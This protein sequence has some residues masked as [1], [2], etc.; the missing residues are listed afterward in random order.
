MWQDTQETMDS[1]S[2]IPPSSNIDA[3]GEPQTALASHEFSRIL[4]NN[5]GEGVYALDRQGRVTFMNP[6]A[7]RLVGW[8][9][10]EMCGKNMHEAVHYQHADGT[11]YPEEDCPLLTV[12]REGQ[13]LRLEDVF[14]HRDGTI[15]P[16]TYVASP[17]L[18]NGKIIGAVLAFHDIT[19]RK[20]HEAEREHM[21]SV[22]AHE[23]RTPLTS[24]KALTQITRRRIARGVPFGERVFEQ[25]EHSV[26]RMNLLVNDLLDAARLEAGRPA[27]EITRFNLSALCE[28]A[29]EEQMAASGRSIAVELPERA[30]EVRA[31]T[32]RVLQ[33]LTNLL[34]NALK[35]SPAEAAVSL[36]L[37]V[38]SAPAQGERRARGGVAC[39]EV[40]DEGTG[41]PAEQ[42]GKLFERFYRAPGI[43]VQHGSG[44]GLGLGLY[45]SRRLV[46]HMDG[47]IGVR[48]APGEG[49]T[50]WFTLPLA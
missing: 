17:I 42:Q 48:S 16:I 3:N 33:V 38:E 47:A 49:T 26:D 25:F 15:F 23:L 45:I 32:D 20:Q 27:I 18:K 41:I 50:F 9:E 13:T 11:P 19:E 8:T 28:Q 6:A 34:S 5:L 21:L 35:Y 24:M 37:R 43:E 29:V 30:V 4:T 44:V 31:D 1:A 7:E 46:E 10:A 2:A 12:L 14:T 36:R 22:V 40:H 39:V